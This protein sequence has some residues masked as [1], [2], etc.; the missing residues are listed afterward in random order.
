MDMSRLYDMGLMKENGSTYDEIATKFEL[1]HQRVHQLIGAY[2][3][4]DP[5]ICIRICKSCSH[6]YD[7]KITDWG[8]KFCKRGCVVADAIKR[9]QTCKTTKELHKISGTTLKD[10]TLAQY[11]ICR[12]C[13]T[14][15]ARVWRITSPNA[16]QILEKARKYQE[17]KNPHKMSARQAVRTAILNGNLVRPGICS[18]CLLEKK[19]DAHHP[20]YSKPLEVIWLCRQCHADVHK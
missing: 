4:K 20:D 11:Y 17:E 13:N 12:D 2:F 14:S 16:H 19:P 9:C 18:V 1:S 5:N 8:R 6:E 15:R 7:C 10:G 3:P